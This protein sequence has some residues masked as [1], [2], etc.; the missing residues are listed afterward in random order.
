MITEHKCDIVALAEYNEPIDNLCDSINKDSS[1]KFKHL[2]LTKGCKKITGIINAKYTVEIVQEHA[3]YQIAKIETTWYTLLFAAIHNVSNLHG[4]KERQEALLKEFH[5]DILS[6]EDR[7]K[8]KNTVV[9][10]DLNINPFEPM[11]VRADILHAIPYPEE[12]EKPTRIITDKEY[13]KFY[14][15]TW[16][17]L[18]KNEIP[19]ATYYYK[20]GGIV[21]YYWYMY[22]QVIIRPCLLNSF[23]C[24]SLDII[25]K[26]ENHSL[27]KNYRP[28]AN[29]YSDHLPIFCKLRE[30][31]IQ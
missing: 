16:K 1:V 4:E 3:R 6:A 18:G 11:C 26:T 7:C 23:D 13:H 28:D 5:A 20:K 30:E 31:K 8:T 22:D 21:N 17:L 15:P 29:N 10:G 2:S 27:L 25:I 9:I 14:N 24:D 12:V 19:Y